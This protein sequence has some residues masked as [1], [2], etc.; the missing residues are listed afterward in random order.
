MNCLDANGPIEEYEVKYFLT[1]SD[2]GINVMVSDRMLVISDLVAGRQYS[3]QVAA[4]NAF[5]S[6][7]FSD[8]IVLVLPGKHPHELLIAFAECT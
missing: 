1:G 6:G 7:P 4:V 8:P 2:N 5:G 3:I